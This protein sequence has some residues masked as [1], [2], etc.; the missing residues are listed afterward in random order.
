M[1]TV[2]SR[3]YI[4]FLDLSRGLP[5]LKCAISD[6]NEGTLFPSQCQSLIFIVRSQLLC[7]SVLV[8]IHNWVTQW[9]LATSADWYPNQ[10]NILIGVLNN[11]DF[12]YI[13]LRSIVLKS[14]PNSI[15]SYCLSIQCV[16]SKIKYAP[17]PLFKLK[18]VSFFFSNNF[19]SMQP[20]AN[21]I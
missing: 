11:I 5:N 13:I 17:H 20:T 15:I 10:F 9:C 18:P 21:D 7:V 12:N 6:C 4:A 3:W 19:P 1:C 2:D 14:I 16:K 8:T